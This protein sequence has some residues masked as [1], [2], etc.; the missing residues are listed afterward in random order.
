MKAYA[1]KVTSSPYLRAITAFVF[2]LTWISTFAYL[3]QQ[4]F[5]AHAFSTPDARTAFF[6]TVDAWVQ[7]LS[8][9]LQLF[10]FG[11]L[12]QAFGFR[13]LLLTVP[14]LMTLGYV[15]I[16][17]FPQ[18]AVVVG[19]M[20]VRRVGEYA[21]TRPCRDTLFTAVT[22][23]EK[24]KAK[25]LIDT[26]VYRAGDVFSGSLHKGLTTLG[27]ATSGIGW[28]GAL[29]GVLWT[30]L[31]LTLGRRFQ[32]ASA[33]RDFAPYPAAGVVGA[34]E[35][36]ALANTTTRPRPAEPPASRFGL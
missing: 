20:I 13:A 28:A 5:V 26:L 6:A 24:Y 25:S 19:V 7:A 29:V 17:L 30:A 23:E 1:S 4:K 32:G 16:G 22:R 2:L 15:A 11:R 35:P 27:L 14:V 10:L 18:F 8:L 31:A 12:Q 9:L 34:L 21:I 3:E 36:S 33:Q